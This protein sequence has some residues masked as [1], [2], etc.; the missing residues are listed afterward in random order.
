MTGLEKKY[1]KLNEILKE[2][3]SAAVA[4]SGGVDST[5]LARAA[6][7]VLGDRMAAVTLEIFPS[8]PGGTRAASEFCADAGIRHIVVR[9]EA[10]SIPGFADNPPD[11]C[12]ICKK[13][14]F[15]GILRVA[16]REHLRWVAEG[17]NRDD[18]SDY[19]PGLRA[20]RELGIR[21][22]LD[23]AGL[24]KQ[25]IRT[26]S[27]E[28]A[29]PTWNMPSAA[30]L[31]SRFAYGER[32]T[33]QKLKMVAEAENYLHSIGFGQLRVRMHGTIAR[34]E[35]LP[36]ELDRFMERSIRETVSGRLREI[37]FSYVTAD[38]SGYRTGSMN[39]ALTDTER[40]A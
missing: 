26:L 12:Y 21:S 16:E 28:L 33:E 22:P 36:E 4:F 32:I 10:L 13:S 38:L 3:G 14:L 39:E 23:E 17:S 18:H 1:Q 5:L 8:I 35:L 29:L 27:K 7:D 20:L 6:H 15:T 40:E 34:I 11:R 2:M 24:T 37:G 30:C 19:R 9:H 31:A 25:E